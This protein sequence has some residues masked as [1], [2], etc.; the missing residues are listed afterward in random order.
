M[1][2][3]RIRTAAGLAV[4][5]IGLLACTNGPAATAPDPAGPA[6]SATPLSPGISSL[7]WQQRAR[8]LVA[9]NR[10]NTFTAGRTYAA[11]SIAQYRAVLGID[12]QLDS[13]GVLP[14]AGMPAGGRSR[15]EA[16][17]GAVAGASVRVLS[18]LYPSAA[19]ALEQQVAA[20]AQS[21]PGD[22]HPH[23]TR[24]VAVG[25]AVGSEMVAHLMSD[26]FS[27]PWTGTVPVGAGFWIP[28]GAPGGANLGGVK[29]YFLNSTSQ[30]RSP[31][32]PAFGSAAFNTDLA[33]VL[34]VSQTRTAQ[35]V[36]LANLWNAPAGTATPLG[37]WT[38]T[39]ESY[40]QQA[41]LDER[42]A[43]HVL[44]LMHGAQFDAQLGCF[45]T[46]YFYFVL[47]PA[48]ANP[49]ITLVFPA[50]NHPSYP[51]FH[52]CISMSAA[53][54]LEH[55]FPA[56]AAELAALVNDAG[57]S[58]LYAGIH[59]RFDITAGQVMGRAV[60]DWVISKDG[61]TP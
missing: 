34:S 8:S 1:R 19:A 6:L 49:A 10:Q 35:Q 12:S 31:P 53:R 16:R 50:P 59:Y 58:R 55:F 29:P 26:G 38:Q 22:V 43:T 54:V 2:T 27:L 57:L 60:A 32:P 42:A 25:R 37:L 30:F 17:R 21:G 18:F 28:N 46:K 4:I 11:L 5:T 23:F 61:A 7:K 14:E 9:D 44:A 3:G 24:G 40:I 51:S 52:S 48:Q 41:R 47:R 39:A 20:E 13:E 15:Y 33:E 45:E 56:H 36:A